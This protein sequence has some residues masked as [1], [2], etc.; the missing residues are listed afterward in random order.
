LGNVCKIYPIYSEKTNVSVLR[1]ERAEADD[2]IARF[3]HLHPD[4]THYI[5]STDS[6]YQQLI[7]ETVSQYNGVTNELITL[8]GY[9]KENGKPVIDKKTKE[10]KLVGRS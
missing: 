5:L 10:P 1:H 6:D 7:S 9:F 2:M 3:I 4:A 8:K